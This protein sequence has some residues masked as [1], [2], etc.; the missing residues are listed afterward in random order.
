MYTDSIL[1]S[2]KMLVDSMFLTK[3]IAELQMKD[4]S[5]VEYSSVVKKLYYFKGEM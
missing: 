1:S 2:Y 3:R 4:L 5:N